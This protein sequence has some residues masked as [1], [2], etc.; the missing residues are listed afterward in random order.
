MFAIFQVY[1]FYR[2]DWASWFQ[3]VYKR[4]ENMFWISLFWQLSVDS[5]ASQ[6]AARVLLSQACEHVRQTHFFWVWLYEVTLQQIV[7]SLVCYVHGHCVATGGLNAQTDTWWWPHHLCC[8]SLYDVYLH[9]HLHEMIQ[10]L[11]LANRTTE[12]TRLEHRRRSRLPIS[13]ASTTV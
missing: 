1:V 3:L 5:P 6:H 8:F 10:L 9:T 13:V 4:Y 7:I 2:W 12:R 11:Y